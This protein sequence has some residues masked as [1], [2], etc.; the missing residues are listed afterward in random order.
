MGKPPRQ[1]YTKEFREPAARLVIEQ[2][3]TIPAAAK[4]LSMSGQ[5][6]SNWVFKARH[7]KRA[8]MERDILK[9]ATATFAKAQLRGHAHMRMLQPHTP[10]AL[11]YR[12]FEVSKSGYH[13]F[14]SRVPSKRAQGNARLIVAIHAARMCASD[15]PERLQDE[16]RD[17]GF[18]AGVGRIQRFRTK[19]GLRCKQVRKVNT[20][21]NSNH[22]LPVA[23]NL[24]NQ[25]F[26]ST[27]PNET[28]VT[29]IPYVATDEG[30]G[31]LS[32]VKDLHTCELVGHALGA[33]LTKDLVGR[34]LV[35]A[36]CAKPLD[37]GA[38]PPFG[39]RRAV[40]LT[41]L[42]GSAARVRHESVPVEA[43]QLL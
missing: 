35:K 21:T 24:L 40:L 41:G 31:Y 6:L 29:D 38:D 26:Q 8:G 19:L 4:R 36:V 10:V 42:P 17:D 18:N 11:R 12:V 20:T 22:D 32:G 34:A 43:R 30:W 5:T 7:G 37:A 25:N 13:A 33:R 2:D 28:W 9:K 14:V 27:Y 3:L 23:P 16:L 39:S 15:G 1:K